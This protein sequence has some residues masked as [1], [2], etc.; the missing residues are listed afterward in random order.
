MAVPL[1]GKENKLITLLKSY[2]SAVIAYSGGTDSTLLAVLAKE[3]LGDKHLAVTAAS[4]TYTS[5]ELK[6]A[7][8]IAKQF[9]L[10][11]QV[12]TTDEL[13][14]PTFTANPV[15]RCFHCKNH[16]L[17]IVHEVALQRGFTAVLDG[18][19]ADDGRDYRPGRKAVEGWGVNSPLAEAGLTKAEIRR[20]AK[21]KKLPNWNKPAN[22]C[23]ASRVPYG[24]VISADVLSRIERAERALF[25]MGFRHHRVRHHGDIARI[26][27]PPADL[28]KAIK[29]RAQLIRQVKTAGYKFVTLDLAG[30]QMGCFNP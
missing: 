2:G 28:P 12:V 30:Y 1:K 21:R 29:R 26:E 10:N 3:A 15:D 22:A 5:A 6:Q 7:K 23:L 14:D 18:T 11:L 13:D 27:L 9:G 16:L 24:T 19:N 25:K 4:P 8:A 20:I 17:K